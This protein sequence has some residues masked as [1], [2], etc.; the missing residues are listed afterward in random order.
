MLQLAD[1][2]DPVPA[3]GEVIVRIRAAGVNPVDAYVRTG[4]YS[5]LPQL[6]YIPGFDG[7]GEIESVGDEVT[8][9]SPGERVWIS[10][11]GAWRGTYAERLRCTMD[12]V[13][14]LP[15][16]LSFEAGAAL[17]VPAATA[18]RALFGRAQA[19]SGETALVHGGSGAVGLAAIQL[20]RA[21]GLRVFATAGSD[22]GRATAEEAGAEQV[23]DHHDPGRL[24]RIREIT[25]GRGV[26]IVIEMLAN[27]N[28]DADLTLLGL[29]GRVVVVGSRGRVEIDPRATMG[30]DASIM[31]MALWNV[32]P[33][34]RVAINHAL[35]SALEQRTLTPRIG[36]TFPL[37]E[38]PR[39]HEALFQPGGTRGKIVLLP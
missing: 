31:G 29:H 16:G 18:H 26:D 24:D 25:G 15:D 20:A 9:W 37:D 30:K 3:A 2:P 28:L 4:Q 39:A 34:E 22:E 23:F 1:V 21:A 14:R 10:T 12:Q 5:R 7:A 13:F 33:K 17:G 32:P 27:A 19:K 35:V 36:L 38:A 8:T 6:P 11:L